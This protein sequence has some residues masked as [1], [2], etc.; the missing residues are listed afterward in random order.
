MGIPQD[1]IFNA[2]PT[3]EAL[4]GKGAFKMKTAGGE[5]IA[6]N[7]IK[8][9]NPNGSAY[10][11]YEQANNAP[12]D[13]FTRGFDHWRQYSWMTTISGI[14]EFKNSGKEKIFD[15]LAEKSAVT[16]MTATENLNK[17]L[18]NITDSVTTGVTG[19]SGKQINSIPLLVSKDAAT[20]NF[21]VHGINASTSPYWRNRVKAAT[22]MTTDRLFVSGIQN[23][24][25]TANRGRGGGKVDILVF[26]QIS[27]E[28]FVQS[29]REKV[30][31]MSTDSASPGF[32][33]VNYGGV[34]CIW[35]VYVPDA[36]TPGD[37]GP[38]VTLTKGSIYGLNSKC[39][40]LYCGSGKDF[41]STP[42]VD[43]TYAAQDAKQSMM[44]FY[45]QL[46]ADSRR[47]QI[48]I[49]NVPLTVGT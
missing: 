44:L 43:G 1:A 42:F 10:A 4:R 27:H 11:G 13:E 25:N 17:D 49:H 5:V 19:T 16:Y 7:V 40:K 39:M 12:S 18:W 45:G 26:D 15:L 32:N 24:L 47:N 28:L 3:L 22:G 31:Y 14:E 34:E 37:G 36:T 35:D 41:T 33:K 6:F 29:L 48:V 20:A 21:N 38:D 9:E 23:A 46:I 30:R 2:I 8:D